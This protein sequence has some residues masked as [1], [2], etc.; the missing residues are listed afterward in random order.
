MIRRK[1]A[2]IKIVYFIDGAELFAGVNSDDCTVDGCHPNDMGFYRMARV[3]GNR[4]E[5]IISE[6]RNHK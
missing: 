6:E 2:A 5:K 4:L 3:I 1:S